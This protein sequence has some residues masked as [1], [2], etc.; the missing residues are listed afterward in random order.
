MRRFRQPPVSAAP[1]CWRTPGGPLPDVARR[2]SPVE[3]GGVVYNEA[4]SV[5]PGN[6]YANAMLAHWI[7]FQADDVPRAAK[8]FDTAVRRGARID[9]VRVLQWAAYGN[10]RSPE[11]RGRARAAGGCACVA[12]AKGEHGPGAVAVGAVLLGHCRRLA[13]K[14]G[15]SCSRRFRRMITSVR[16]A[17]HSRNMRRMT[18]PG[19]ARS[20]TTSPCCMRGPAAPIRPIAGLRTLDVEM[21]KDPGTL[22]DAVQAA[23]RGCRRAGKSLG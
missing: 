18:T 19:V 20:A 4:L 23:L 22:R 12:T 1:I 15:K 8:L 3:P 9:A 11:A 5:D 7:L 6:P 21:A 2:G 13:N 17:G 14:N 16:W 10:D